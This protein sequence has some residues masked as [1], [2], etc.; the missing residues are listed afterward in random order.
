VPFGGKAADARELGLAYAIVALREQNAVYRDRAFDLLR[1][2]Q[3]TQPGDPQTLSYL[4]DLYKGRSDHG[5]AARL[6]QLLLPLHPA[7]AS[8][9]AAL[10][11][12]QMEQGHYEEA[13]RLWKQALQ[14]S[15]ALLLVRVNLAAALLRT[16]HRDEARAVLVKALEFNPEFPA[17]LKLLDEIR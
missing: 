14:I 12:Y 1:E 11:G 8:A 9:P 15:P 6:Y 5:E 16:G 7:Q 13:I 3:R 17:A 2:G 4:A 10:G